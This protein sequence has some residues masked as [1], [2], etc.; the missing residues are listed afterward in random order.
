[1]SSIERILSLI[2]QSNLTAA[3]FLRAVK[4]NS[5][6]INDWKKGKAKPSYGALVKI[7][8]Y[9]NV[10]VEYLEGKTDDPTPKH[11]PTITSCEKLGKDIKQVFMDAG[12]LK[13]GEDLSAELR[14]YAVNLVRSAVVMKTN[15]GDQQRI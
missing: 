10:S 11:K 8:D 15:A 7:A 13:P 1:M 4:L 5:S 6:S 12:H 14:E 3:S 2:N 9:F